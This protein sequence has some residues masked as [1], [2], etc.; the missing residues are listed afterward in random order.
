MI[1]TAI[2]LALAATLNQP[3]ACTDRVVNA[4]TAAGWEGRD[5]RT[6]Y[7]IAWRESNHDPREVSPSD[8][9]GL[10]QINRPTWGGTRYWPDQPLNRRSNSRAAHAIWEHA[11]WQPWGLTDDGRAVDTS[12]YGWSDWQVDAWIWRPYLDGLQLWREL[13]RECR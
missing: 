10:F 12:D 1:D 13:P 5:I 7:A 2:A 6:A 8:D 9:W 11:G 4:I 3:P